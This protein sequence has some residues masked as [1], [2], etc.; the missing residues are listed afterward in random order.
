MI[1]FSVLSE[2]CESYLDNDGLNPV[3]AA[4][5]HSDISEGSSHQPRAELSLTMR[6]LF[7][8]MF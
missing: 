1:K 7:R 4:E 5:V 8:T 2:I 3:D 6:L